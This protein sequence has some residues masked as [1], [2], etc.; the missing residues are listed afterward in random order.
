M[1]YWMHFQQVCNP[2]QS[3][4]SGMAEAETNGDVLMKSIGARLLAVLLI[5]AAAALGWMIFS[6]IQEQGA[7]SARNEA[8]DPTPVSA[9]PIKR[10]PIALRRTFSGELE[11]LPSSWWHPR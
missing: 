5:G 1:C 6:R 2:R 10:G 9:A 4:P 11:A 3:P 7:S 8:A